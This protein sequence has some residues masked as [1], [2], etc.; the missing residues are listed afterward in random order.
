VFD[1]EIVPMTSTM[2]VTD[3]A[4]GETSEEGS[5][6]VQGRGQPRRHDP[7]RP[8]EAEAPVFKRRRSSIKEG[9]F[10]TA[11][12]ASQLSDGAAAVGADGSRQGS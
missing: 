2:L 1:A 3:K 4:T 5:H 8:Q 11:G 7:G 10:V 12:N 6:P 9:K